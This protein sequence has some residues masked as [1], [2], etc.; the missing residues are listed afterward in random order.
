MHY[1]IDGYNLLFRIPAANL[2]KHSF[3]D[4]RKAVILHLNSYVKTL[5]LKVSVVFDSVDPSNDPIRRSHY[6]ALEV[7]YTAPKTTAD[8]LLLEI[9]SQT[10][11]PGLLCIVT[12]DQALAN[13]VRSFR[14]STLSLEDFL[15][16]VSKKQQK[17]QIPEG[18]PS[19]GSAWENKRLESIFE[20]RWKAQGGTPL[21]LEED[22]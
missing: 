16:L 9:A 17:R 5:G 13:K 12:S 6:D 22:F 20:E 3:E 19:R 14:V 15:A 4:K 7:V 21:E 8:D 2:P 10:D 11:R 18:K 1:W